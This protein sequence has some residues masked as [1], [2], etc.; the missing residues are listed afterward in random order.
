MEVSYIKG[1]HDMI[2]NA[3][4]LILMVMHVVLSKT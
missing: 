2:V 1:G 3:H 4:V